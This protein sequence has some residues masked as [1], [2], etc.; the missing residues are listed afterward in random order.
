VSITSSLDGPAD[1]HDANRPYLGGGPSQAEVVKKLA[2]VRERCSSKP[3][4]SGLGPSAIMTTTRASLGRA[5]D[6]VDAYAAA[7]LN[8]I[9]LRPL[10]PVGWAKRAWPQVGYDPKQWLPFYSQGLERCIELTESGRTM[11]ERQALIL[12]VKILGGRDPGFVD[13][14]SPAG[15]VLG[16]L[17]YNY[18]GGIFVSDEG[19]IASH[20]G[21][22]RFKVGDVAKDSWLA[23]LAHPTTRACVS[24]SLLE[25]QP[26]CHQCAYSPYCGV[27]P[28]YHYE[29]QGNMVGRM[30]ESGWCTVLM[31]VFDEIFRRLQRPR[32]RKVFESWLA[33]DACWQGEKKA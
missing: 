30:P 31:G 23:V 14:R 15:A 11:V 7:G 28:V 18:D 9:Y 17:A 8:Q 20:E 33:G 1:L 19:R 10:S 29:A 12:L 16:A 22:E 26:L 5:R 6:V 24:S 21:E 13:L 32:D 3:E 27:E 2:R 4:W 25:N